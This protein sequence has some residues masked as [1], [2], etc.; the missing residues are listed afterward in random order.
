MKIETGIILRNAGKND[1]VIEMANGDLYQMLRTS[2]IKIYGNGRVNFEKWK[3]FRI[4]PGD[5]K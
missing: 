2:A 3:A 5:A 1:I 4:E